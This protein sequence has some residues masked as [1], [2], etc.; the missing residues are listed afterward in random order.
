MGEKRRRQLAALLRLRLDQLPPAARQRQ[1][2]RLR[3]QSLLLYIAARAP[4]NARRRI[5]IVIASTFYT[6]TSQRMGLRPT[7]LSNFMDQS[8]LAC[9][10]SRP[11]YPVKRSLHVNGS[12]VRY[13]GGAILRLHGRRGSRMTLVR[14]KAEKS[15]SPNSISRPQISRTWVMKLDLYILKRACLTDSLPVRFIVKG[16]ASL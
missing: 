16:I 2:R 6:G 9:A 13:V 11:M 1:P 14:V 10:S 4:L 15:F 8:T 3:P 5:R 12:F 7:I